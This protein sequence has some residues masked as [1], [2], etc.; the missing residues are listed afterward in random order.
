M[1]KKIVIVTHHYVR[2]L[3]N[4]KKTRMRDYCIGISE[5]KRRLDYLVKQYSIITPELFIKA[6]KYNAFLPENAMLLTFDDGY[7]DHYK[8]VFPALMERGIKACFFPS[9]MP[10]FEK[11][12][13]NT[14][15]I[16]L[17]LDMKDKELLHHEISK[18]TR[19]VCTGSILEKVEKVIAIDDLNENED[20][21]WSYLEWGLPRYMANR[22]IDN[23]FK[24]LINSS[25]KELCE[26][27]YMSLEQLMQMKLSGMYIGC[28][29]YNHY[30]MSYVNDRAKNDEII[31]S[32]KL[33]KLIYDSDK[34]WIMCYPYGS[35]DKRLISIIK[36]RGCIA[37]LTT[38]DGKADLLK[39][40]PYAL[41]RID[42][43]NDRFNPN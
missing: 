11:K 7:L 40:N 30:C 41:P 36:K 8:N 35:F 12:M 18:V 10:I 2:D 22:I 20:N 33:L 28:H 38:M 4:P 14:N 23:L 42:I 25:E 26:N 5:F 13:L 34:D 43:T 16:Q 6:V 27:Y 17:I 32:L 1:S 15:K 21:I 9:A 3:R 31:K 39:D 24:R 37:G 19:A 29:G